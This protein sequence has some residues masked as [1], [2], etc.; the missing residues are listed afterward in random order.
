MDI[1]YPPKEGIPRIA[2]ILGQD[3]S[4]RPHNNTS[5]PGKGISI[6]HN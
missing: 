6:I 2:N 5:Y 1:E 3:I 4:H